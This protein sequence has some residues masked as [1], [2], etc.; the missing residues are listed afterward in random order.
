MA[1]FPYARD[2]WYFP[3]TGVAER[4]YREIAT[5][6]RDARLVRLADAEPGAAADL[7]AAAAL[8]PHVP[9]ETQ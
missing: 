4:K 3:G 9:K 7:V 6:E 2:R 5:G 8:R 1:S